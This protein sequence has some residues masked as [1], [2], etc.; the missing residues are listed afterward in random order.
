[1][2]IEPLLKA[3]EKMST[4]F[5]STLL[6]TL[7]VEFSVL[8]ADDNVLYWNQHGTRIFKR[9]PG[10]I[11]RNARMCHP[12]K[13]LHKI[14]K[15]LKYLK[16]GERDHIDFWLDLPDGDKP[17]KVLIQYHAIRGEDGKYLGTLETSMNLTPFKAI[18]GENR[19]GDF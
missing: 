9:G 17:R 19:L 5:L 6:D 10:I 8:D 4:G 7:P 14:E 15:V 11:G 18:T 12:E 13:S 3:L 16:S 2:T 1:M